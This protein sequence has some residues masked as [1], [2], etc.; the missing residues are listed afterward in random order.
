MT[1]GI[2]YLLFASLSSSDLPPLSSEVVT[3][4]LGLVINTPPKGRRRK[5]RRK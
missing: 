3:D 2:M 4:L 5:R 1:V